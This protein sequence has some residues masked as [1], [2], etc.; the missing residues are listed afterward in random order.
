M[1]IVSQVFQLDESLYGKVALSG[2]AEMAFGGL[3][4][5]RVRL[6]RIVGLSGQVTLV[7]HS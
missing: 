6:N 7:G 4:M 3:F 1:S 2:T 5:G